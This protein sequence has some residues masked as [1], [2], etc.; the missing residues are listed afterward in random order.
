MQCETLFDTLLR[1]RKKVAIVAVAGSSIERI[2]RE[3]DLDYFAESYDHQVTD[4]VRGLLEASSH[5]FIVAG[6]TDHGARL[7]PVTGKGTHGDD[8]PADME[9]NHFFGF[10]P[11]HA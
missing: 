8:I 10:A 3:R 11:G 1:A 5:D 9:V 4:R 7:D 2:F 6:L